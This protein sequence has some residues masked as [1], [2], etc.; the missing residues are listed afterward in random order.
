MCTL[1]S[2]K[3]PNIALNKPTEQYPGKYQNG[4]SDKAVDGITEHSSFASECA[5][6]YWVDTSSASWWRVD[7]GDAVRIIG[8]KIYNRDRY[9]MCLLAFITLHI[10]MSVI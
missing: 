9:S 1:V 8:I 6:T 5:H 4:T 10:I 7:L 3:G 2:I